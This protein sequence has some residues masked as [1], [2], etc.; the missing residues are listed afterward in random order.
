MRGKGIKDIINTAQTC[1]KEVQEGLDIIQGGGNG[2]EERGSKS[3]IEEIMKGVKEIKKGK[4]KLAGSSGRHIK[5]P[6]GG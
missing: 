3:S 1:A 6:Q 2:L 5:A 4:K